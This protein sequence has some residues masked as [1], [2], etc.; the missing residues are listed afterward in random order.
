VR[1]GDAAGI[2][3]NAREINNKILS[4]RLADSSYGD[5]Q[6]VLARDWCLVKISHQPALSLVSSSSSDLSWTVLD[7]YYDNVTAWYYAYGDWQWNNQNYKSEVNPGCDSDVDYHDGGLDGTGLR[8]SGGEFQIRPG[9]FSATGFGNS[10]YNSYINDYGTMNL[11]LS[12]ANQYGV[13]FTGQDLVTKMVDDQ[14]LCPGPWDDSMWGGSITVG[15]DLLN[16]SCT[17]SQLFGGYFH[18][19]SSTSINSIGAYDNG[20]SVGWISQGHDWSKAGV[21]E[22]AQIC[23]TH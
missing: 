21:G 18:T 2:D 12:D 22:T 7:I 20:F 10:A 6:N 17:N 9:G 15:F 5:I 1:K 3:I 23:N 19:W 8:F 14:G 16:G 4:M 11:N 13:T